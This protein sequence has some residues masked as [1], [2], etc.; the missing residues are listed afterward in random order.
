MSPRVR[1]RGLAAFLV[2]TGLVF[3]LPGGV[4]RAVNLNPFPGL[5]L[6]T[7]QTQPPVP[8]ARFAIDGR[9]LVTDARGI[10]T[11]LITKEQREAVHADR[12]AHLTVVSP[13]L[14]FRSGARAR[15]SGWYGTG[16]Y[17]PG[18]IPEEIQRATFDVDFLTT[19]GFRTPHGQ[20]VS[21]GRVS[22][23]E[24]R[25]SVGG[26]LFLTGPRRFAPR[27]LHGQR[28]TRGPNGLE[29][30]EISYTIESAT[31]SGSNV[32]NQS[33]QRFLPSRDPKMQIRLLLFDVRLQ[34][35]DAVF[36][37]PAGSSVLVKFPDGTTRR[38]SLQRR[39]SVTLSKL[40][41][42]EYHVT[43]EGAGPSTGQ[44][45]V[46]SRDQRV[47]IDVITWLDVL[48]GGLLLLVITGAVLYAGSHVRRR[49]RRARRRAGTLARH[50]AGSPDDHELVGSA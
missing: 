9:E 26:K 13:A 49:R 42:G 39:A 14:E 33:Q 10:V 32:V 16:S 50:P 23:M 20:E 25:S 34:A 37:S 1:R 41:R 31:V 8:G 15:F 19:F 44:P 24:L 6:L 48:L 5:R 28:V 17:K 18:A 43:V 46:L 22:E 21:P 3:S 27:W 7:I 12:A 35:S 38:E 30:V 36:G 2:T 4:A 45:F 11:T 47:Q 29:V 40:P